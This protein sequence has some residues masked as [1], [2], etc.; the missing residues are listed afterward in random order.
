MST[1]PLADTVGESR[2]SAALAA[3][4][5]P[6]AR[7]S[8]ELAIDAA[9]ERERWLR[10]SGIYLRVKVS[11]HPTWAGTWR[12]GVRWSFTAPLCCGSLFGRLPALSTQR[13]AQGMNDRAA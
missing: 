7:I 10:I 5:R 13:T 12:A 8:T 2:W 11:R 9:R 4:T 6:M 3:G 1:A